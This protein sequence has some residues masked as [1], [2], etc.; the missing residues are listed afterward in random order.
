M[1]NIYTHLFAGVIKAYLPPFLTMP[2]IN[3]ILLIDDD[4][5]N[6]YI[7]ARLLK[8]LAVSNNIRIAVNGEEGLAYLDNLTTAQEEDIPDLILLDINMPVVDGF[9]FLERFSELNFD[10]KNPV[11]VML[12]TSSNEK[13]ISR[14]K[15][16]PRVAGYLN[17]PLTEEKIKTVI[18]EH[19]AESFHPS[20]VSNK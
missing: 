12:T 20:F 19:F 18:A 16:H 2:M 13:D 3:H 14:V 5:V 7:N 8:K 4:D 9:E 15:G 17:K 10:K 1:D 6:N 11:V